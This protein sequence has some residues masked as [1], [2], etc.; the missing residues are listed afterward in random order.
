MLP[1][2]QISMI[3][4]SRAP[5][6]RTGDGP[7]A[8]QPFNS[9]LS[10]SGPQ[11]SYKHAPSVSLL[12]TGAV[13]QL[14]ISHFHGAKTSGLTILMRSVGFKLI[15]GRLRPKT[16]DTPWRASRAF[17]ATAPPSRNSFIESP[18]HTPQSSPLTAA[19]RPGYRRG[20]QFDYLCP[21]RRL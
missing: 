18:T 5:A 20:H 12:P 11:A 2:V 7:L 16:Y 1:L 21:G 9:Y 14:S 15:D 4:C 17:C 3:S 6:Y 8:V 19:G 10:H 13:V